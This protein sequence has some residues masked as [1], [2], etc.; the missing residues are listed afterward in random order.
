MLLSPGDVATTSQNSPAAADADAPAALAKAPLVAALATGAPNAAAKQESVSGD[1]LVLGNQCVHTITLLSVC[2]L[3]Y[4]L[5][6][7]LI[8]KKQLACPHQQLPA[9][10]VCCASRE[11]KQPAGACASQRTKQHSET[12]AVNIT[13]TTADVPCRHATERDSKRSQQSR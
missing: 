2:Q 1:N 12:H 4:L 11:G 6:P 5:T 10:P 8:V 3:H 13:L 7:H 9:R